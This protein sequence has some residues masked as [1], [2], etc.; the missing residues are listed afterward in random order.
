MKIFRSCIMTV[1][2]VGLFLMAGRYFLTAYKAYATHKNKKAVLIRQVRWLGQLQSEREQKL[3]SI[4]RINNFV[5]NAK[6]LG[7]ELN[8]WAVYNVDIQDRVTFAEMKTV[9][10]QCSNADSHYFRPVS[11]H[12]KSLKATGNKEEASEM[13]FENEAGDILMTLKGAFVVKNRSVLMQ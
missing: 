6:L 1:L 11:F 9:L 12:I 2:L 3:H 10:K 13:M 7:L 8:K 5:N 4:L